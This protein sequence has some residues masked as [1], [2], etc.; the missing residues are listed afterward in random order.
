MLVCLLHLEGHKEH[1]IVICFTVVALF[2]S[3]PCS[4]LCMTLHY[5]R[6][7]NDNQ[8]TYMQYHYTSMYVGRPVA[9][10]VPIVPRFFQLGIFISRMHI[11]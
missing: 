2:F 6:H 3:L 5:V 1:T 7:F 9:L 4:N 11:Q 8:F 10:H